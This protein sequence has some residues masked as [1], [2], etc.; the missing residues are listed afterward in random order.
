ML[1]S[2]LSRQQ[3]PEDVDA[4]MAVKL[5]FG[6]VLEGL[7]FEDA[8]VVDEHVRRAQGLLRLLEQPLYLGCLGHVGADCDRPAALVRDVRHRPVGTRFV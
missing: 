1:Q 6:D 3:R 4:E 2:L 7:E 8:G 5:R